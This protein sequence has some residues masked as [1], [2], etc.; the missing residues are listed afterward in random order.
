VSIG[1]YAAAW[2]ALLSV[3]GTARADAPC[4]DEAGARAAFARARALGEQ[5]QLSAARD[6]YERSLT[7]CARIP[8]AYNLAVV[9]L[10]LGEPVA[11]NARA[12]A[13]LV[14]ELGPLDAAQRSAA[15]AIVVQAD[16]AMG[17]VEVRVA[18]GADATVLVDGREPVPVGETGLVSV[19]VDPGLHRVVVRT[20]DGRSAED[21]VRVE[22]GGEVSLRLTL[23]P[24]MAADPGD[25]SEAFVP[26]R[27]RP[28]LWIA[29]GLVVV[30]AAVTTALVVRRRRTDPVEDDVWGRAELPL[31]RF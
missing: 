18:R 16:A 29:V 23:P 3:A 14:G 27:R 12:R 8:T 5:R 4:A 11:A 15:E 26:V 19:R 1:R 9:L 21:Q 28:A 2:V 30:G 13:L 7:A 10:Q 24:P 17:R 6:A 31:L 25:S 22:S 20:P